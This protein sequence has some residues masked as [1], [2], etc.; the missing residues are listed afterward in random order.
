MRPEHIY[1]LKIYPEEQS[2][3]ADAHL[4]D[5]TFAFPPTRQQLIV[6]MSNSVEMS[7]NMS[8]RTGD[9]LLDTMKRLRRDPVISNI[10]VSEHVVVQGK[11]YAVLVERDVIW[12]PDSPPQRTD[13]DC[14]VEWD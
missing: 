12:I 8:S 7:H 3:L 13:A 1:K 5:L 9:L 2:T 10:P 6:A 14:T 4:W 11:V